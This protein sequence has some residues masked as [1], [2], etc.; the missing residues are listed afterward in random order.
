MTKVLDRELATLKKEREHLEREHMGKFVLIHGD[1]V[2][3]VFD[4][5][6]TAANEGLRQFGRKPF[7]IRRV[8][9]NT[10]ELPIAVVYGLT[11]VYPAS[12][13]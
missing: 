4:D 8:G 2:V 13:D 11:D 10:I 3:N 12:P 9:E 6:E 5:F 1:E 7:L